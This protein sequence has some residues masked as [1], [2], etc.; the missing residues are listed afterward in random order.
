MC[1]AVRCVRCG[2]MGWAG[3]GRHVDEVLRGVPKAER[4]DGHPTE[5]RGTFF[6]RFL[7]R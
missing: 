7:G 5:N 1:R 4:C 3:C 2:K 6:S